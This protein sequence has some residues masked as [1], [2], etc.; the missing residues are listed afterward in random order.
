MKVARSVA[1]VLSQH[2]TL[3]LEC[4]DRLY[5][6]VYVP[7]LQRAAGAAYFFR[8]MRGAAVPSPVLMAPSA[9]RFVNAIKGYAER[10]G[11]DIVSF[12]GST[13]YLAVRPGF[14]G[15]RLRPGFLCLDFSFTVGVLDSRPRPLWAGSGSRAGETPHT[16]RS[17]GRRLSGPACG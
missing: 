15:F 3:A 4:I 1:E 11:I 12:C 5:L 7:V 6:N 14:L 10:N 8:K 17:C 2:T 13:R 9:Q 16:G